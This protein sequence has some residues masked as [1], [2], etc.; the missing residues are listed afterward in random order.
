VKQFVDLSSQFSVVRACWEF[1]FCAQASPSP[2]D[3]EL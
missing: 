2:C 3:P 1:I